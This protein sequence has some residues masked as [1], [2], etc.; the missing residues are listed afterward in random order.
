MYVH[1]M[2]FCC[3]HEINNNSNTIMYYSF[4]NQQLHIHQENL[5]ENKLYNVENKIKP[6]IK[7]TNNNIGSYFVG[8][9]SCM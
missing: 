8:R 7:Y 9:C 5:L 6:L 1:K 4:L 3:E 2:L